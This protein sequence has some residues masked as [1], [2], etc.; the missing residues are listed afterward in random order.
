[1][2]TNNILQMEGRVAFVKEYSYG[3]VASICLAVDNGVDRYGR[4]RDALFIQFKSFDSTAYNALRKGMKVRVH[5]HIMPN[6]YE[7]NGEMRYAQD[8]IVKMVEPLESKA[9][10]DEREQRRARAAAAAEAM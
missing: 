9:V 6:K 7:K 1:M 4:K 2:N 8:L 3:K 10:I 5:F